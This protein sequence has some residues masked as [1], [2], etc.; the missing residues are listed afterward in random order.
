[1]AGSKQVMS[2][3]MGALGKRKTKSGKIAHAFMKGY[4]GK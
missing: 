2:K 4:A 1:M 3:M